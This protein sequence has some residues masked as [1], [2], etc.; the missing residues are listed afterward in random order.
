MK[1]IN[2]RERSLEESQR[3][4][5]AGLSCES[6]GQMQQETEHLLLRFKVPCDKALVLLFPSVRSCCDM[7]EHL[8]EQK[9][10]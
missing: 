7:C 9:V 8:G 6:F 2:K 1:N 4:F 3:D 10:S 5:P